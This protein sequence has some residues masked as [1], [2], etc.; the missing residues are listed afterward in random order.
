ME[1][2]RKNLFVNNSTKNMEVMKFI[3]TGLGTEFAERLFVFMGKKIK[4]SV[5]LKRK[6][7]KAVSCPKGNSSGNSKIQQ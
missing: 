5:K 4:K 7:F 2:F 6:R 3:W 1:S